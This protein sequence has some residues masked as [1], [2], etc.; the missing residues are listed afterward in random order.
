MDVFFTFD[1]EIWCEN[2]NSLDAEFPDAMQRCIYGKTPRG[3]YGLPYALQVLE[4][5]GLPGVF[6]VEPLFSTRFGPEPLTEVIGLILEHQQEIQLHL[7]TEWVDE[8]RQPLLENSSDKRQYLFNFSPE[9]QKTL[10][11]TGAQ[12]IQQFTQESVTAFRAGSYGFNKDTLQALAANKIAFDSS[13]DASKFGLKSGVLTGTTVIEP[14]QCEGVFEY[15]VTVYLDGIRGMRHTQLTACSYLE[16]E[17]LLW[18]ALES[19][20]KAFVIVSHSFELL[21]QAKTRPDFIVIKRFHRLCELLQKNQ[22]CFCVRG[23][24]GL[25]GISVSKQPQLLTMPTWKTGL[26]MLQQA[27]RR[28]YS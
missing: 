15:P 25:Q 11:K 18:A 22:D 1:V 27:A 12:L 3:V 17:S 19:G 14:V 28:I 21:N 6:F 10:I 8:S 7:H 20:R 23:F 13:Y 9:E 26:R 24:K 16:L 5:H 2:W 4:D